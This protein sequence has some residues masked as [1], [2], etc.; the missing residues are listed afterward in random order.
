MFHAEDGEVLG[1][2][3]PRA[4]G[5]PFDREKHGTSVSPA[6]DALPDVATT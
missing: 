5:L 3:A 6:E 2:L 4:L 1:I